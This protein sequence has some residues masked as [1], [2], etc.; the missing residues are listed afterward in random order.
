M[1]VAGVFAGTSSHAKSF[2]VFLVPYTAARGCARKS[3]GI[4]GSSIQDRDGCELLMV[5]TVTL[6]FALATVGC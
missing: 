5:V 2:V 4:A 3:S 1:M 6:A